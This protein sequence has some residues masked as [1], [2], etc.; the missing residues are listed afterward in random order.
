MIQQEGSSTSVI[1]A[2]IT[3]ATVALSGVI[4]IVTLLVSRATHK[5]A[6][7]RLTETIDKVDELTAALAV[8]REQTRQ[9]VDDEPVTP[10]TPGS[11]S[12]QAM[13]TVRQ[14]TMGV[15]HE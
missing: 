3:M 6:N 15:P 14:Q 2:F 5:V 11:D 10:A 7:S 4:S 1:I 9:A 12:T 13:P 8:S